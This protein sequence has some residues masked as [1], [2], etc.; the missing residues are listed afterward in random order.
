[1]PTITV[2]DALLHEPASALPHPT[3]RNQPKGVQSMQTACRLTEG[4]EEQHEDSTC[5]TCEKKLEL[6]NQFKVK[7][8]QN[9]LIK[10]N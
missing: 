4:Q 7:G 9:Q 3:Q 1:M 5:G 2:E 8:L 10:P 6:L